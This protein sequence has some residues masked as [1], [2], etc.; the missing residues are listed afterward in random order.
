MMRTIWVDRPRIE[1][2][3]IS[4]TAVLSK[5]ETFRENLAAKYDH[6]MDDKIPLQRCAKIVKALLLSRLHI[7][8]LHRYH[9]SVASP[10]PDRLRNITH[11]SGT[12]VLE[13]AVALG[14]LP[15]VRN[16]AWYAGALQQY[17]TA[18]LLLT[19]VHIYP[20]LKEADRIWA[21]LDWIYECD[22]SEHRA[23][24]ARRLLSELRRKT[25]VYQSLR[26]M[27]APV[28]SEKHLGQRAPQI[29]DIQEPKD[30]IPLK[31][32]SRS[33]NIS[34]KRAETLPRGASSIGEMPFQDIVVFAGVSNGESLWAMPNQQSPEASS[35]STS[36][37]G[38]PPV[39][40][41]GTGVDELMA[42]IDW[43][44][45][46]VWT[47]LL[48]LTLFPRMLSMCCSLRTNKM[49]I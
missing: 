45:A 36:V 31:F 47:V 26:G 46:E 38:Q 23:I 11:A 10:M 8:V 7:M 43:V 25:A 16:W 40:A 49:R 13:T 9:H 5:I 41:P 27:R 20:N 34:E 4:L 15:E 24:K 39:P 17:H 33:P 30:S 6:L 35:D 19:E 28:V 37:V 21:C 32:M 1:R 29:A 12:T 3:K 44:C 2:R 22:P 14:T 18:F 48:E 42:D